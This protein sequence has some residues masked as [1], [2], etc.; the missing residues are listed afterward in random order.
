MNKQKLFIIA[1]I[2]LFV[3]SVLIVGFIGAQKAKAIG[4]TCDI[5]LGSFFCWE[6]HKVFQGSYDSFENQDIEIYKEEVLKE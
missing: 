6:W 1:I 3:I 4:A 2:I 5:G